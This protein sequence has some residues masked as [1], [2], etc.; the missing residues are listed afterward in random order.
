MPTDHRPQP[1]QTS[2][3]PGGARA[4]REPAVKGWHSSEP[5]FAASRDATRTSKEL[6]M[7]KIT[8]PLNPMQACFKHRWG[9][10]PP[11]STL[12][13]AWALAF[14]CNA[15]WR[16]TLSEDHICRFSVVSRCSWSMWKILLELKH[17]LHS[18]G[19]RQVWCVLHGSTWEGRK[20]GQKL[21]LT[22]PQS[23]RP[24]WTTC[25]LLNKYKKRGSSWQ[26][27]PIT[28]VFLNV[29]HFFLKTMT[30]EI[31]VTTYKCYSKDR[32]EDNCSHFRRWRLHSKGNHQWRNCDGGFGKHTS[33]KRSGWE[34]SSKPRALQCS[35]LGHTA[36]AGFVIGAVVVGN[37]RRLALFHLLF[38]CLLE[39][40]CHYVAWTGLKSQSPAS[41][42]CVT[43]PSANYPIFK[44]AANRGLERWLR[45]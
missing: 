17:L 19:V 15:S 23:L 31:K 14:I 16:Y 20:E 34:R 3:T 40:P 26:N 13:R 30:I 32:N 7:Q 33:V 12:S 2:T 41:V 18:C 9:S 36:S 24:A 29:C 39:T 43:I 38:F 35:A 1:Q 4:G 6:Q 21:Q 10:S 8:M 44:R 25:L 11:I 45:G 28:L 27:V 42:S 22:Y 37:S 5:R